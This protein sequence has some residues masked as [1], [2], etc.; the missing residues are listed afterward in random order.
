[1]RNLF[2]IIV[3]VCWFLSGC[4]QQE[5]SEKII[6]CG[7]VE[8][9]SEAYLI[10]KN[11][12][13]TD[14]IKP[15]KSSGFK[16]E[17]LLQFSSYFTLK[18]NRGIIN[19]Y[20]KP[21]DSLA[22]YFDTE[23]MNES[24]RFSG[25]GTSENNFLFEKMKYLEKNPE[26]TDFAGLDENSFMKK[27]DSVYQA[28]LVF[29]DRYV[30]QNKETEPD[31][32][33]TEKS[34]CLYSWA[35][36]N[37]RFEAAYESYLKKDN[38]GLGSKFHNYLSRVDFNDSTLTDIFEYR[39]FIESYLNNRAGLLT[40]DFEATGDM[41]FFTNKIK[42]LNEKVRNKKVKNRLLRD[43]F[44]DHIRYFGIRGLGPLYLQFSKECSNQ[45]YISEVKTIYDKWS[46]I[47]SGNKAFD[48]SL[49][50]ATGKTH[51]LAEFKGKLVYIDV[52][53]TWCAPCRRE[54]PFMQKLY[55]EYKNKN[56]VFVSISVDDLIED[57]KKMLHIEKPGW[58]QLH[59]DRKQSSLLEDYIISTIPRF[60]LID[61]NGLIIDAQAPAASGDIRGLL[62]RI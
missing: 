8:N 36:T 15:D 21:G 45:K 16:K 49:P 46:A 62:K 19:L 20:L 12:E 18:S 61:E 4:S 37:T 59:A 17:I 22:I 43:Y 14:T 39:A 6:L 11:E 25:T 28:S 38:Q 2:L 34:R 57:W 23:K 58:L 42:A 56:I 30:K 53:A 44:R 5:K 7:K 33:Q 52:W 54:I 1:M 31:F 13:I 29:L 3:V 27:N 60:I 48:F 9:M 40:K 26:L 24:L 41:D 47:S 51:E 55:A 35:E 10:L 50:D 32:I